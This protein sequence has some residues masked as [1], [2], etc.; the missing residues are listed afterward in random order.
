MKKWLSLEINTITKFLLF[1][2][3]IIDGDFCL[4]IDKYNYFV[5]SM[6]K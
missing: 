1:R 4:I 6:R 2:V 5:I 3:N